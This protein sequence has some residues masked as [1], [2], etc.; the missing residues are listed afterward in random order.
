MLKIQNDLDYDKTSATNDFYINN[1]I[2]NILVDYNILDIFITSKQR[3]YVLNLIFE[4][5]EHSVIRKQYTILS[6]NVLQV[7]D[8][9]EQYVSLTNSGIYYYIP[10]KNSGDAI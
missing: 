3:T 9:E 6:K 10:Y 2:A 1:R 5:A 8:L 7:V 4:D